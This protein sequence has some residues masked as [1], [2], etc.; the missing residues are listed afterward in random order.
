M[1]LYYCIND[2]LDSLEKM[3]ESEDRFHS[4]IPVADEPPECDGHEEDAFTLS[5]SPKLLD[6]LDPENAYQL[7]QLV[8]EVPLYGINLELLLDQ[9]LFE[10][11]KNVRVES[12]LNQAF[13]N[14]PLPNTL[15]AGDRHD[16]D[17]SGGLRHP[18]L[19]HLD[20][21]EICALYIKFVKLLDRDHY[22]YGFERNILGKHMERFLERYD[23]FTAIE[24]GKIKAGILL[25]FGQRLDHEPGKSAD[26]HIQTGRKA[27]SKM[28]IDEPHELIWAWLEA[29]NYQMRRCFAID[30]VMKLK[31][32]PRTPNWVRTDVFS[33]FGK[34]TMKQVFAQGLVK[35]DAALAL[36]NNAP[37]LQKAIQ[38]SARNE[39]QEPLK[40]LM[41]L[42][43]NPK[44]AYSGAALDFAQGAE[45]RKTEAKRN[46]L[47]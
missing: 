4:L 3:E 20:K 19:S 42:S 18:M 31:G 25:A 6:L 28:R 5:S 44:A 10:R 7:A 46:S 33:C 21:N 27:A 17:L 30:R 34:E 47:S 23:G 15:R 32:L 11:H 12:A 9:A 45:K 13:G 39:I 14:Q 2:V 35:N 43:R 38:A 1:T 37:S 29:E 8:E 16:E 41:D 24:G 40:A 26:D 36:L 22:S